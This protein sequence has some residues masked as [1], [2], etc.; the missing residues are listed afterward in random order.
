MMFIIFYG[1]IVCLLSFGDHVGA[2]ELFDKAK[3]Y[4]SKEEEQIKKKKKSK[5]LW[6][7][8]SIPRTDYILLED[9]EII[10]VGNLKI[11]SILVPGHISGT[12]AYLVDD[13]YLFTGDILSLKDGKIAPDTR[14]L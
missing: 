8:N 10:Q 12:M 9:R 7:G 6:F 13:K 2:L 4:M 5:F 1:F 3:L 11:E 14:V